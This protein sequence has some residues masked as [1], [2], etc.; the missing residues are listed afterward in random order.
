VLCFLEQS[1]FVRKYRRKALKKGENMNLNSLSNTQLFASFENLVHSERKITAQVLECIAEIDRR[2]LYLKKNFTSLF[3]YLVKELGYS[4]GAAMRR[5]DGARLLRELPEVIEKVQN[6][7]I[8]LSQANQ[9]ERA[10]RELKKNKNEVL[11]TED[12]RAL[13][14]QIENT[15]QKQTE[16]ILA[17]TLDL[18]MVPVQKETLHKDQSVTLTITFTPEQMQILEKAQNMISHAVPN[19]NW[20]EIVT[21]LAKRE[22]VRRTDVR[23]PSAQKVNQDQLCNNESTV[24]APVTVVAAVKP[25][26]RPAIP[27]AVRKELIRSSATCSHT[28]QLGK[29][30]ENKKFL[31]I[32]HI[33]SWSRGGSH[34]PQNLQVLCATHNRLKYNRE[35]KNQFD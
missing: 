3:D 17:T 10:S 9:L 28:D 20:A 26:K 35:A 22:V 33:H 11:S 27:A 15:T 14:L 21:H 12:K 18:P 32:D 7:S 2:K 31:Q 16:Q 6:G 8:T 5:I 30:C 4:P 19:K 23:K 34:E 29:Q 25:E 13:L 1:K 24:F